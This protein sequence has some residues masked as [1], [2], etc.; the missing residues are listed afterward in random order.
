MDPTHWL[1]STQVAGV[2][3]YHPVNCVADAKLA[4]VRRGLAQG[5]NA[6]EGMS[7]PR[8]DMPLG[9]VAGSVRA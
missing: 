3:Y 5:H 7:M 8:Q 4:P 9:A 1:I 6:M 2:G